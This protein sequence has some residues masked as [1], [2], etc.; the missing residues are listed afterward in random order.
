MAI[1]EQGDLVSWC[2]T[3][4]FSTNIWLHQGGKNKEITQGGVAT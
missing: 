3:S 4:L 1:F 2:L